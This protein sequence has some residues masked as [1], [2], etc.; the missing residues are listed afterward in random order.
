M[1]RLITTVAILTLGLP[2]C[3]QTQAQSPSPQ[4]TPGADEDASA[5]VALPPATLVGSWRSPRVDMLLS[6]DLDRDVYG[7]NAV[8]SRITNVVIRSS[9]EGTLT[10][11]RRIVDRR[12]RAVAGTRSV[13]EVQFVVGAADQNRAGLPRY[14]GKVVRAERRYLDPPVDRFTLEGAGVEFYQGAEG[15]RDQLQVHFDTPDG[16]GSFTETLRRV[17]ASGSQ[18]E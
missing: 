13:E 18:P 7:P 16:K 8:S 6:S 9:G 10:V 14:Q 11:T 4:Q 17:R 1:N 15:T 2:L 5:N 12:G 3:G